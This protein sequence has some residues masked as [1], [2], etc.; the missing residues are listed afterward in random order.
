MKI[1]VTSSSFARVLRRGELTHLEWIEACS[2]RLGVDGAVFSL[3]DFPRT[4]REYAAQVKKVA[5]D[6][7]IVPVALDVPGLLDPDL[8]DEVRAEA[9]AL[10]T[11]I[12]AA[13][14]RVTAG[15]P[16]ELPPETFA[17]TVA[18]TKTFT[19][20]A[21]AANVTLTVAPEAESMLGELA[22]LQTFGKYVD[23]AWL[24]YDLPAASSERSLLG[25]RDRVLIE[26]IGLDENPNAFVTPGARG[27]FVLEGDGGDDPFVRVGEAVELVLGAIIG[28][29]PQMPSVVPG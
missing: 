13:L 29:R 7:G 3:A 28:Q 12:G 5:T 6:L 18:S 23:S 25:S 17:R 26:R 22:A 11:A 27:W 19:S 15:P 4:D 9:L 14:I 10:A 2:S 16:G 21:K 20:A 24:R 8:G 1:A